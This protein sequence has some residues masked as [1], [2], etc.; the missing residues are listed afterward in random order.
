MRSRPYINFTIDLCLLDY[1]GFLQNLIV[2]KKLDLI[3]RVEP[4][5]ATG[6][7]LHSFHWLPPE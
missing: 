3:N 2:P 5:D 1:T 7:E 6:N 4:G